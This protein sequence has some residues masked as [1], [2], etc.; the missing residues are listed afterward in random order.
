MSSVDD[1]K[2]FRSKVVEI[3]AIRF[4]GNNISK[5]IEAW[6]AD[7]GRAVIEQ[8]SDSHL[9]IFTLEGNHRAD[10]GDW[11]IK[12]LIGEFYPCKDEVFKQKYEPV[13][14]QSRGER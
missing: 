8:V 11:I 3:E 6:G 4:E 13:E 5:M 2:R 10:I 12:G 14:E 7:F 9:V 1:V